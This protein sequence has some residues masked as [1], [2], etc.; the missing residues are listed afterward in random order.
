[1]QVDVGQHVLGGVVALEDSRR[2]VVGVLRRQGVN[3][4]RQIRCIAPRCQSLCKAMFWNFL[5]AFV[6]C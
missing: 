2:F 6:G 1:M 3:S 4:M 5:R